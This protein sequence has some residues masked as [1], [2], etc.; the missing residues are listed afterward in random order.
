MI[1]SY[2]ELLIKKFNRSKTRFLPQKRHN[3]HTSTKQKDYN[4][5]GK[6]KLHFMIVISSI[7]Y[8][9]NKLCDKFV[10]CGKKDAFEC[11]CECSRFLD[12]FSKLGR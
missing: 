8:L 6:I 9:L 10:N 11:K 12:D 4:Y 5:S 7:F 1:S 3:E 2:T